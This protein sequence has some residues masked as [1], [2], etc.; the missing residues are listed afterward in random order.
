[1][2]NSPLQNGRI[3]QIALVVPNIEAAIAAW[4]DA[5]SVT[6]PDYIVTD[7]V[8]KAQTAYKGNATPAR[9]KLAFFNLGPITLELIEPMDAPSTWNDQLVEHGPSLH[10]I[11][12]EIKGMTDHVAAFAEQGAQMVQRGEYEGGRYAYI[13]AT[14]QLGAVIELLEND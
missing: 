8:E 11:A 9:A 12:F 7:T 6:P 14:A 10:H 13:D 2:N 4:S 1:M 3:T 5:L